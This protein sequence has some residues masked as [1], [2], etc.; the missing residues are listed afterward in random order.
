MLCSVGEELHKMLK[1]L[2]SMLRV[3]RA[4]VGAL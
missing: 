2:W 1:R 4:G 3:R